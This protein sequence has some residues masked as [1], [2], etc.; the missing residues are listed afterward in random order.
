MW[1]E[2]F[3]TS[4]WQAAITRKNQAGETRRKKELAE[5]RGKLRRYFA[6]RKVSRVYLIGSILCPG[7]FDEQADIDIAVLGL[8]GNFFRISAEL[9]ALVGRDL[10]LIELEQ[11][12]FANEVER[13]G[14]RIL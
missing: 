7:A 14:L 8:E 5:L 9:E 2:Q 3:D 10:D 1:K 13:E 6:R 12:R 11:C 4:R